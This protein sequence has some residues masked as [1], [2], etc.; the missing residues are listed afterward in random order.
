MHLR[1]E[2]TSHFLGSSNFYKEQI[3]K[4]S[5]APV[6]SFEATTLKVTTLISQNFKH[7]FLRI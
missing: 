3:L 4:S 5:D 2:L 7:I 1:I 6:D